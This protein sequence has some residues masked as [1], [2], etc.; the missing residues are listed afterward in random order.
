MRRSFVAVRVRWFQ[1]VGRH[2]RIEAG[3]QQS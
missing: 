3:P 1:T 2:P